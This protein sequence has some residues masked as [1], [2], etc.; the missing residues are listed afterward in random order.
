MHGE[1]KLKGWSPFEA[2]E[3]IHWGRGLIWRAAVKMRGLT[4]RGGDAFADD[5]GIMRWKLFD[6]IPLVNASGPDITRSAGRMNI[7]SIWL[8]SALLNRAT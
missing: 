8:P 4:I 1:I 3:V 2:D 7:E 6:L 5:Q